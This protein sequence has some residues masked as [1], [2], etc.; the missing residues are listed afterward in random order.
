MREV[1][2]RFVRPGIETFEELRGA[3]HEL[4]RQMQAVAKAIRHGDAQPER[5]VLFARHCAQ[6]A[7]EHE[8]RLSRVIAG[9]RRNR[10]RGQSGLTT[11]TA[12]T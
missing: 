4:G 3:V 5:A 1:C 9:E 2:T 6:R 7:F 11:V 10:L 12:I 8:N